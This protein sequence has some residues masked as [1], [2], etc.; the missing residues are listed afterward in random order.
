MVNKVTKVTWK[1]QA[2]RAY[3]LELLEI[4]SMQFQFVEYQLKFQCQSSF[5][6]TL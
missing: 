1:N 2:K 5:Y 4:Y 3:I 6:A